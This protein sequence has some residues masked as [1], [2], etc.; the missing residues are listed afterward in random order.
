[1]SEISQITLPNGESYTF[2]GNTYY[3]EGTQN[4][5]TSEWTGYF[6]EGIDDYYHGLS[7]EYF[8]TK[9]ST[10]N[11]ASLN[12]SGKGAKPVY[13]SGGEQITTHFPKY[14]VI[15]FTYIVN[16]DLNKGKGCFIATGFYTKSY[17]AVNET[18]GTAQLVGNINATNITGWTPNTPTQVISKQVVID[19]ENTKH[20][21]DK[22][23]LDIREGHV[24]MGESVEVINGTPAEL[25]YENKS[26]PNINVIDKS[27]TVNIKETEEE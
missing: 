10:Q 24:T 7:I 23:V 21:Y 2:E 9:D 5:S 13:T 19:A 17:E 18:I 25:T 15:H 6:P 1:M 14:S 3:I 4:E 22:G 20:K 16:M 11:P 26:I 27:V 12:L 8:L